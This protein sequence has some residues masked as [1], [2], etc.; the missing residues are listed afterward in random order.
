MSHQAELVR[1]GEVSPREL[2][3]LYLGRIERLDPKLNAFRVVMSERALAGADEAERRRSAGETAPLLGVPIAIKDN[4]DVAGE[5]TT[6]GT[7][8]FDEPAAADCEMVRRLRAAG[9]IVIGKTNLPELATSAFTETDTWGIT[10]N[11]WNPERTPNGSSGGSAVAVA[12]GLAAGASASDGA[13]SIRGPAA[14]CGLVGL[15][16]QR[17]RISMM[18]DPEHWEGLSVAGCVSRNVADTALWLDVTAG[19]AAGDVDAAAAPERPFAESAKTAPGTLRV[20]ASVRPIRPVGPPIVSDEVKGAVE[21]AARVLGAL[22]HGVEWRDPDYGQ[23]GNSATP[24]YLA[25][26]AGDFAKLPNPQRAM[27]YT[28]G[29]ARMGR[30]YPGPVVRRAKAAREK[31][32]ARINSLF[33]D[34]DVLVTC[35]AGLAPYEVE[36]WAG[37]GAIRTVYGMSRIHCFN[38]VWNYVGN[39]AMSVPMGFTR[40]GLPLAVQI[41]GRPNDEATLLSLASQ[42]EAELDW[43]S[44]HPPA[45]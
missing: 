9:A 41:V 33:D 8:C 16:P 6:H 38:I 42:L 18:P 13:G 35:V 1:A 40:D 39:P 37:Q 23:V 36:K 24:L 29:L 11:P 32:A 20:A 34:F 27:G 45:S 43:P 25:G 44:R 19:P 21:E 3:E 26:V 15:K 30:L 5:I 4:E 7:A 10:R 2:V 31:W 28:K 17:G 14:Y 22:G 12:A